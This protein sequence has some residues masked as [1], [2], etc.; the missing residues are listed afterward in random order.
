VRAWAWVAQRPR[1]YALGTRFAA[2]YLRMLGGGQ[3]MI[4][5]LP[6]G[7][8]WTLGREMP[9]PQGRTFREL[10]AVRVKDS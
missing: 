4:T 8:G 7:K 3:R 2:R 10:Y 9:A 5:H 1:L 6:L